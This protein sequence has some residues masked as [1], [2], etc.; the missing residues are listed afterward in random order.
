MSPALTQ[1]FQA[2]LHQCKVPTEWK[3]ANIMPVFKKGERSNPSNHRPVSL[4]CVCSKLLIY[5]HIFEHLNAHGL[6]CEQQHGFQQSE[7]QLIATVNEIA[8]NMNAGKQTDVI[9]L[10]FA[11]AF[12]KVPHVRLCHKLSHLGINGPVLEGIKDFLAGRTQQVIVSGEKSSISSVTSGVPQGTV[13]APL[14]FLCFINDITSNISSSIR[15]YADDV[16][17]YR[18]VNTKEDVAILQK[19][20][21]ILENWAYKWNMFF[22]PPKCEFLRITNR[23]DII[24]SK[25]TIQNIEIQEVQH[26]KYLGVTF[27]TK[28][29]WSDHIQIMCK[30]LTR[31]LIPYVE[32]LIPALSK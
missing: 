13:L 24:H 29:K 18:C 5:S 3:T 12:D 23:K 19:D 30:R 2:S 16:L 28:L 22:S 21:H 26:A 7:T 32:T 9:L 10:D 17:I 15:L 25:Y 11:K 4:T 27:N 14:L 8:E 6:L 1:I 31:Y 20:L